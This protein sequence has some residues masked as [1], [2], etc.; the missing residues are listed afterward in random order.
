MHLLD[1]LIVIFPLIGVIFIIRRTARY[2][3]SVAG[4]LS[5][6]RSARRYLI[7]NARGEAGYGA[8]S[9]VA[10][11][12]VIYGSGLTL[13]WWGQL[14]ITATL[15]LALTGFVVYRYRET[16]ALT[17]AQFFE[18]RYSK[19]FRICT[20]S[21]AFLAGVVNYGI[22]PGVSARFI[23][24]LCGLPEAV[25]LGGL[26]V[27]TFAIIMVL[28]LSLAL[29]LTLSGGQITIMITDCALG[30]FSGILYLIICAFLIWHFGWEQISS[31]LSNQPAGYSLLNPFDSL[32]VA[33]FNI[34]YVLIGITLS[35]YGTMAWQGGQAYN[36]AAASAHEAKMAGILGGWRGMTLG[37]F[38]MLLGICAYTF[39]NHPDFSAGA[40]KVAERL[41]HI[42]TEQGRSEM[43]VP[44]ALSEILPL[45]LR[46]MFCAVI[47]FSW[48]AVDSS[49]LHS[50]GSI[51]IQDI[52]LPFRKK[53]FEVATHLRLLRVSIIAVAVFGFF[54]SLFFRQVEY[55]MMYFAITG[56]IY[57]GG[58]GAAII[59]G[60]YWK[61]GTTSGAWTALILGSLLSVGSIIYKQLHPDFPVNGQVLALLAAVVAATSYIVVSLLTCRQNF[62]MDRLLH[63]GKYSLEPATTAVEPASRSI[64]KAGG[65]LLGFG[66]E[67]T[68]GDRWI[69]GSLFAYTIFFLSVFLIGTLW[70]FIRPWPTSWWSIYWHFSA[71][72]LPMIIGVITTVWISL[73]GLADLKTFLAALRHNKSSVTDDGIVVNHQN[74]NEYEK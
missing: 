51:F 57:I 9:A 7:C 28:G 41:G 66:P 44:I 59:G 47:L 65:E 68:R 45:G 27:P 30:I 19:A 25:A 39:L 60:L 6:E 21:I 34:W 18:L 67:F 5:A 29:F 48:I 37:L 2:N 64:W 61:K 50:W 38:V 31:A 10:A 22:F 72:L 63:R 11:F 46:G 23:V 58:A 74:L 14:G 32:A 16:R 36:S 55:I 8:I 70:N 33:D 35:V 24:H 1:W 71:V 12:Q 56:A 17:L 15:L 52:V 54:F 69:S 49:Y 26:Q 40:A 4:F 73:G 20:G 43:R 53:P 13:S 42:P 3:K 62:N